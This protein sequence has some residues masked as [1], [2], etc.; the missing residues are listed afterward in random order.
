M[1]PLPTCNNRL[2]L[3]PAL[4]QKILFQES[5]KRVQKKKLMITLVIMVVTLSQYSNRNKKEPLTIVSH[6]V[7]RGEITILD[8]TNAMVML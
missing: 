6:H 5:S 8:Q 2:P 3:T 7:D 4:L 1:C